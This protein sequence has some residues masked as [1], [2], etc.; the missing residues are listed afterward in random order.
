MTHL[1]DDG[2]P[3]RWAVQDERQAMV[4]DDDHTV[5]GLFKSGYQPHQYKEWLIG[6][7]TTIL[8]DDLAISSAG[9]I[10]NR[11]VAWVEVSMPE[12]LSTPEGFDFRPNLLA[13][14]SFD[15]SVATTYKRTITA[16]VCDNTYDMA[17]SE[18]GQT[19]KAR[20]SKYSGMR[21]TEAR[22]AL[23]IV[24]SMAEDFAAEIAALSRVEVTDKEWS[25]IL[26][27]L[28][29]VG[30]DQS[31]VA[32]TR[33]EKKREE[34]SGMY[35]ANP[36]CAPWSGTALGVIQTFNTWE[37]HLKPVKGG[38]IR[39]ERNMAEAINGALGK[40]DLCVREA[41]AKVLQAA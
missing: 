40:S 30:E 12:T 18:K 17:M 32:N 11:A 20:H 39:A 25:A 24:H 28:I 7:V 10:K 38:T 6:N 36:M 26:D 4:T 19:F 21:I 9:L 15:G 14:T 35:R 8:D 5:M 41:L 22:D 29:P 3:M 33:G 34:I 1:S 2:E 13:T 16:T 31:K 27:L 23:G 37:Q